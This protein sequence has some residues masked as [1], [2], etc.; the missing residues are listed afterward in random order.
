MWLDMLNI[1]QSYRSGT[2]GITGG[3]IRHPIKTITK[4][5]QNFQNYHNYQNYPQKMP[6]P[7]VSGVTYH[8]YSRGQTRA[9]YSI[10]SGTLI[11]IIHFINAVATVKVC[12]WNFDATTHQSPNQSYAYKLTCTNSGPRSRISFCLGVDLISCAV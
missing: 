6:I 4:N 11:N 3:R 12:L 7:S 9:D 2:D 5:Y 10:V 8:D 1:Y